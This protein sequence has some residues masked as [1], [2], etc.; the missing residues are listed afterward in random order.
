MTSNLQIHKL[1]APSRIV[2]IDDSQSV[3][4][5]VG[6]LVSTMIENSDPQL[7]SDPIAALEWLSQNQADLVIVDYV[8]PKMD[9]VQF[10]EKF[11][12]ETGQASVPIIMVTSTV[13][14]EV[15]YQALQ[16]GATDFL[17]KPIDKIEFLTRVQNLLA[18][19]NNLKATAAYAARAEAADRSKSA[20][21]ANMSH[22][23][24]TPMNAIIG[25]SQLALRT[26]PSPKQLEYLTKINSAA[27]SLMGIINDILDFSKIE[28]GAMT[29][30][31]I[32]FDLDKVFSDL[33]TALQLR[34]AEKS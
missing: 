23:I 22:E 9:G 26:D 4:K 17:R 3:L 10:V 6:N 8:M 2:I 21:L 24:R 15:C 5:Y 31:L 33:N 7:F 16:V 12:N 30:E 34:V 32:N 20:F 29:M 27:N 18:L 13:T 28:A 1:D 19:H 11:R 25:F 14:K